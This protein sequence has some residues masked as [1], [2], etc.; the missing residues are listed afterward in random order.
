MVTEPSNADIAVMS[1]E[2]ALKQLEKIVDDL[3][4]GDVPL[5]ESIRIYERGE[6]LKKHCDTLLKSAE[7]KVEKIR[8]GRDGQPVGTEPL[9]AE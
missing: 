6:A 7:D 3:E 4:R 2:D 5:E 8:I 1:F 9:D